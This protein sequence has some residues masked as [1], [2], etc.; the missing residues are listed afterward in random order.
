MWMVHADLVL[1]AQIGQFFRW[2]VGIAVGL[3][4]VSI[5]FGVWIVVRVRR[6]REELAEPPQPEDPLQ[7]YEDMVD[8]GSLDPDEFARIKDRLEGKMEDVHDETA[9]T[10]KPPDTSIKE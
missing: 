6:W 2:D 4:I 8:E 10:D 1:F 9:P 7:S 5:V 3:L